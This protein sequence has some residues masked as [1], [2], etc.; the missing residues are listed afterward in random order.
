MIRNVDEG[1]RTLIKRGVNGEDVDVDFDI[2][3]KDWAAKRNKPTVNVFLFDVREELIRRRVEPRRILGE[4]GQVTGRKLPPR[5][6]RLTYLVTAWTSRPEDEHQLLSLVLHSLLPYEEIPAD[7]LGDVGEALDSSVH[8][9][10]G[11]PPPAERSIGEIWNALGGELKPSVELRVIAPFELDRELPAG[12]PVEEEP[13]FDV[14]GEDGQDE[15]V[16]GGR[17]PR[18]DSDLPPRPDPI[19]ETI[20]AGSED[21]RGRI[22]TVKTLDHS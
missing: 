11:I 3:S 10:V 5:F 22:F 14:H 2:P 15:R 21:G 4:N 18:R 17:A 19:E 7:V 16:G 12:P 20:V 13:R 8:M 6:F 1:I 9:A